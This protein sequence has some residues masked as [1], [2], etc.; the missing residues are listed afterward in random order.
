M[1]N[2]ALLRKRPLCSW[3]L[4][5][6][7]LPLANALLCW[8]FQG[9]PLFMDSIF[10]AA[11]AAVFG[12]WQ[13]LLAAFLTNGFIEVLSGFSGLHLP[14]ALCG[15]ATA[16]IV[17][18]SVR[19]R[20]FW[21][22]LGAAASVLAVVLANAVLGASIA[23]FVYGGSTRV[24]IDSIAAGFAVIA[25]SIFTAAFLAR[26]PINFIDKAIAV[27]PALALAKALGGAGSAPGAAAAD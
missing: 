15:A 25:D 20:R 21:S 3:L 1:N 5:A 9:L 19:S 14:F 22:P 11:A 23:T 16:L 24:N 27:L 26:L 2:L 18:A 7:L 10:T 8:L 4:S 17:A 12:P 6:T 13:G